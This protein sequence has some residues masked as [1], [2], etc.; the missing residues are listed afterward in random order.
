MK[1]I[2]V[3]LLAAILCFALCSC[4]SSLITTVKGY[5]GYDTVERPADYLETKENDLYVYDVYKKY[6]ELVEYKGGETDVIVPTEID[7]K[8]VTVIGSSCFYGNNTI[9]TLVV[10][11]GITDIENAA[12]YYCTS[13]RRAR[14]P[15]SCVSYGEKLFSWCTALESITL[16]AGMTVI[17]DYAFNNCT[18]LSEIIWNSTVTHIGV[19][20]FSWCDSLTDVILPQSVEYISGYAFYHCGTLQTV[21]VPAG[22]RYAESAF[23]ECDN[24]VVSGGITE[25]DISDIPAAE[26]S[27]PAADVSNDIS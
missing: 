16:P 12:F 18:A 8:P 23:Y 1:K 14:L 9:E 4:N 17:P 11:E 21:S 15:D 22:T 20:A 24:A 25:S 5:L 7:G 3:F 10:P 2:A 13:L 19:R 6:I 27:L 26:S